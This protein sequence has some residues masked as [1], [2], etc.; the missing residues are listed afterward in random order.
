[1]RSL[2]ATIV[3][4]LNKLYIRLTV[5][6]L[7]I[8]ASTALCGQS[9]PVPRDPEG[10][11]LIQRAE[12][13]LVGERRVRDGI[14]RGKLESRIEMMG[15][16]VVTTADVTLEF[17]G[18]THS[19]IDLHPNSFLAASGAE[20]CTLNSSGEILSASVPAPG[21][22]APVTIARAQGHGN[23]T[24]CWSVPTWFFP[25]MLLESAMENPR[26]AIVYR[27]SKDSPHEVLRL[28]QVSAGNDL[29]LWQNLTV[30]EVQLD[31]RTLS[32]VAIRFWRGVQ[33]QS[34]PL[35]PADPLSPA[36]RPIE[37]RYSDYRKVDGV[38]VPFHLEWS[39]GKTLTVSINIDTIRLN[40]GLSASDFA[41]SGKIEPETPPQP[42]DR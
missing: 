33:Q 30:H 42:Q 27:V 36:N 11:R 39:Q 6:V 8:I 29:S 9:A 2:C 37:V 38:L 21:T 31:H 16:A 28:Y 41:V 25:A 26:C 17:M 12:T 24:N 19:R 18:G 3:H 5:G 40:T 4:M 1:V 7:S 32:P 13:A 15:S 14:L 22:D 23:Y 34:V 20:I 35:P 10:L